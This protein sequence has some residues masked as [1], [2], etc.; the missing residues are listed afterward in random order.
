MIIGFFG[1]AYV[2][3]GPFQVGDCI[4]RDVTGF[5]MATFADITIDFVMYSTLLTSPLVY[6]SCTSS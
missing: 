3:T 1:S 5:L 6:A 2:L 4:Y